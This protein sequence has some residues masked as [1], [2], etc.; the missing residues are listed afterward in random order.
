MQNV[1]WYDSIP[2]VGGGSCLFER[3]LITKSDALLL[4]CLDRTGWCDCLGFFLVTLVGKD[5]CFDTRGLDAKPVAGMGT[6]KMGTAGELRDASMVCVCI[7][8]W[9]L[10]IHDLVV[11]P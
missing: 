7:H 6:M 8:D 10:G 11:H 3:H 4:L 5:E 1:W 2:G 9:C